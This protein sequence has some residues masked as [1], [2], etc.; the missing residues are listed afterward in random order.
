M[1]I[2]NPHSPCRA[3]QLKILG[4][5]TLPCVPSKKKNPLYPGAAIVYDGEVPSLELF[6]AD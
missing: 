4:F 3:T 6:D 1:T 2:F 5:T